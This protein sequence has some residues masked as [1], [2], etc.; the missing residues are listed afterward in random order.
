MSL[1]AVELILYGT[2]LMMSTITRESFG[3]II[4]NGAEQKNY[5]FYEYEWFTYLTSEEKFYVDSACSVMN[6]A[7]LSFCLISKA[8]RWTA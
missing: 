2:L 3:M 4:N 6:S 7:H 5:K 8:I 1:T